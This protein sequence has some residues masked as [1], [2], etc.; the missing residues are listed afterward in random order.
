MKHYKATNMQ[1]RE[2]RIQSGSSA[3]EGELSVPENASGTVPF[4]N[5]SGSSRHS[6]RNQ[7]GARIIREAAG[8]GNTDRKGGD[9]VK[10][11]S[12]PD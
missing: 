12:R 3:L 5:G 7:H 4:A 2:V 1:S 8:L 9:Y 6:P 11:I 10:T